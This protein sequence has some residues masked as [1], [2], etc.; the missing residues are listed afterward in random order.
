MTSTLLQSL[1]VYAVVAC[2]AAY[3]AW[4]LAPAALKRFVA[5]ALLARSSALRA[6]PR[7][8]ALARRDGGC[9]TGCGGCAGAGRTD[10]RAAKDA[11]KVRIVRRP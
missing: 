3:A 7:L 5:G 9:G 11:T 4:T 6:S 8:Q 2:C 1:A 10:R